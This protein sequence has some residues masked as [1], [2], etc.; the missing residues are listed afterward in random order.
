MEHEFPENEWET[1]PDGNDMGCLGIKDPIKTAGDTLAT[2]EMDW[3]QFDERTL[4]L[5]QIRL[6]ENKI[7]RDPF[8]QDKDFFA[9]EMIKTLLLSFQQPF[10]SFKKLAEF[11]AEKRREIQEG[12]EEQVRGYY[13]DVLEIFSDKSKKLSRAAE[14]SFQKESYFSALSVLELLEKNSIQDLTLEELQSVKEGLREKAADNNAIISLYEIN[15]L[16]FES[17]VEKDWSFS[18]YIG[19][20]AVLL[21]GYHEKLILFFESTLQ[22]LKEKSITSKLQQTNVVTFQ[23]ALTD[24]IVKLKRGELKTVNDAWCSIKAY[25]G[26]EMDFLDLRLR[27]DRA[28]DF[29]VQRKQDS[30]TKFSIYY[31]DYEEKIKEFLE[32]HRQDRLAVIRETLG[33]QELALTISMK[34]KWVHTS[35]IFFDAI[36]GHLDSCCQKIFDLIHEQKE[37]VDQRSQILEHIAEIHWWFANMMPYERGSAAVAHLAAA[38]LMI[39]AN[40]GFT[41]VEKGIC[42]DIESFLTPLHEFKEKYAKFFEEVYYP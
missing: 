4:G 20:I 3:S 23:E 38:H 1:L 25:K 19:D 26:E 27:F 30:A 28:E 2:L 15:Q 42:I 29:C 7:A 22:K 8:L 33:D 39:K 5:F 41:R 31:A 12:I 10:E 18:D 40:I 21:P 24:V 36:W 34:D 32:A 14:R 13:D 17:K 9:K 35:P 37:G 11:L 16:V 6:K